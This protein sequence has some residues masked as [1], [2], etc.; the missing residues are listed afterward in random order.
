MGGNLIS[1]KDGGLPG[2]QNDFIAN[3]VLDENGQLVSPQIENNFTSK[4]DYDVSNN[5]IFIGKGEIGSSTIDAV[6]QIKKLTYDGSNNLTSILWA[7]GSKNF[8][9]VWNDRAIYSYS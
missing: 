7:G 8:A 5:L 1:K 4:L 3:G 2:T 9:F 6:W